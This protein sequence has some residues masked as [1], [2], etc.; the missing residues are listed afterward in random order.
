MFGWKIPVFSSFWSDF[1]ILM[2]NSIGLGEDAWLRGGLL[3]LIFQKLG[4]GF[5]FSKLGFITNSLFTFFNLLSQISS[6]GSVLRMEIVDNYIFKVGK[7]VRIVDVRLANDIGIIN[8]KFIVLICSWMLEPPSNFLSIVWIHH[9]L[10]FNNFLLNSSSTRF[11]SLQ[12]YLLFH[13][14]IPQ[15]S[16]RGW[17]TNCL[18][19]L[20]SAFIP[21]IPFLDFHIPPKHMINSLKNYKF[22]FRPKK[23]A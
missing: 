8:R 22:K 2:T 16:N 9:L 13:S 11:I 5:L 4:L 20:L 21:F 18:S 3:T 1:S 10:R 12:L 23:F 17:L 7:L 14:N 19:N 6:F 15:A